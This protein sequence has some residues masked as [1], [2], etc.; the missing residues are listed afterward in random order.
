MNEKEIHFFGIEMDPNEAKEIVYPN[1]NNKNKNNIK[2]NKKT[3]KVKWQGGRT[4]RAWE[5][6]LERDI[7]FLFS[8][9]CFFL[10]FTEIGS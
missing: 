6:E 3:I 9:L 4:D 1:N 8:S 10:R 7:L 2:K 5:N